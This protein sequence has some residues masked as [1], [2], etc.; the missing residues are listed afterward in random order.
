MTFARSEISTTAILAGPA[1]EANA[2]SQCPKA[3]AYFDL[4]RWQ[5]YPVR[6]AARK[7]VEGRA[8]GTSGRAVLP[9]AAIHT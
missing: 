4:R 7:I 2:Q 1:T 3:Q 9:P 5:Q 6:I 8:D